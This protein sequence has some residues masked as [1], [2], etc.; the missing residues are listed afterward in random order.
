MLIT[1]I[2]Y[3]PLVQHWVCDLKTCL[4]FGDFVS[5][6]PSPNVLVSTCGQTAGEEEDATEMKA[7]RC[8]WTI[9]SHRECLGS[10][11][12]LVVHALKP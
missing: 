4:T 3:N 12:T 2:S 5:P 7:L 9:A 8:I 6:P 1:K 10:S 11:D